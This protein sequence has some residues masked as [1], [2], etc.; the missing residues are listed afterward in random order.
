VPSDAYETI[1]SIGGPESSQ[2]FKHSCKSQE[3]QKSF[4]IT[5]E[6]AYAG[7]G[8]PRGVHSIEKEEQAN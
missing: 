4:R 7:G 6:E 2:T 5:A 8:W 1:L 3:L